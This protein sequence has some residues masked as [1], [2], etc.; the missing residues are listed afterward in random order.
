LE[1]KTGHL[2]KSLW[3]SSN[4]YITNITLKCTVRYVVNTD[5]ITQHLCIANTDDIT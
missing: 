3:T 1:I 2:K 4:S 5:N